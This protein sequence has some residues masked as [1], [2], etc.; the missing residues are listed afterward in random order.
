M[1]TTKISNKQ[2]VQ[3]D[4]SSEALKR[5]EDLKDRLDAS[6]KAEVVHNV[7]ELYE[8]FAIQVENDVIVEIKDKNGETIF[9]VPA[10]VLLS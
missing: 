6:T 1:D 7:L 8:C 5:L 3:F 2:R 9:C 4:F 10:R